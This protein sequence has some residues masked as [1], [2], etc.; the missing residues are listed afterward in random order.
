MKKVVRLTESD[1]VR[2]V[3]K[4]IN[5]QDWQNYNPVPINKNKI[6]QIKKE[7]ERSKIDIEKDIV[8]ILEQ[9]LLN[10]VVQFYLDPQQKQKASML[11]VSGIRYI[12]GKNTYDDTNTHQIVIEFDHTQEG[13]TFDIWF[14]Y[15]CGNE[16][17]LVKP[18]EL[19]HKKYY[20]KQFTDYIYNNYCKLLPPEKPTRKPDFSSIQKPTNPPQSFA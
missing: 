19:E 6:P 15:S 5:E 18:Y 7:P 16:L 4:V 14:S 20:N 11:K 8:D 10:K 9:K 3:K 13:Q 2:L 17:D 1:L 12:G